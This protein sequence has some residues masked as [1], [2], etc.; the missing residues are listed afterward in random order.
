M[1]N[2]NKKIL[3]IGEVL[4]DRL[5]N[6]D[7]PG[8]ALMNVALHLH[9]LGNKVKIA[10]SVG[11]DS[12]GEQLLNY[13]DNAGLN[14]D[15]IQINYNLPTSEV[16]VILDEINNPRFEIL[17]PVAWDN[18]ILSD[19]INE[20]AK[21]AGIIVYGTLASRNAVSRNTI[22]ALLDYDNLKFIDVNLRSPFDNKEI[23]D[24]L[25]KKANIAKMNISE[26]KTLA[27][28][29]NIGSNDIYELTRWCSEKYELELVC[30]TRGEEGALIFDQERIFENSGFKVKT[31]DTVGS[32]DAFLA[33]FIFSYFNGKT[34][35]ASL[36]FS[37]ALG[38]YVATKRGANPE[39]SINNIESIAST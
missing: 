21:D 38:A 26:L 39:Y 13:I 7:V 4:W 18:I 35:P 23:V 28:W 37:C 3:C 15:L 33:G 14:T 24:Q 6:G 10:S 2:K 17:E 29:N 9:K 8:G 34:I 1:K 27:K 25:I 36:K 30:I 16:L 20:S 19:S 5:P 12:L 31:V 32:G 11:K 22:L